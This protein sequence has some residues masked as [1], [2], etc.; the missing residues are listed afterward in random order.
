MYESREI[1]KNTVLPPFS[2]C[3]KGYKWKPCI[4]TSLGLGMRNIHVTTMTIAVSRNAADY[5]LTQKPRCLV[6]WLKL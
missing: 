3:L 2:I 5:A 4:H 1:I 6:G